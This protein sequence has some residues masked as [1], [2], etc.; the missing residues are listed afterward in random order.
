MLWLLAETVSGGTA[1]EWFQVG[2]GVFGSGFALWYAWYS[3]TK[4]IPRMQEDHAAQIQ[5]LSE[6][7]AVQIRQL[8]EHYE[9]VIDGIVNRFSIEMAEQRKIERERFNL[10]TSSMDRV[11]SRFED[12]ADKLGSSI[13]K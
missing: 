4:I 5:K 7:H 3:T 2:S 9:R 6:S 13:H 8:S 11:A 12:A 1:P 10:H